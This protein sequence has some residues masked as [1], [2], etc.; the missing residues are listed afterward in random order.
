MF[1][2]IQKALE[3]IQ[4]FSIGIENPNSITEQEKQI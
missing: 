1:S 2:D 3:N 4:D